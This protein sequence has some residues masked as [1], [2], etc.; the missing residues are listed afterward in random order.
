MK[1]MKFPVLILI[2][3]ALLLSATNAAQCG[4]QARGALCKGGL[5]CSKF[6]YCGSTKAYCGPGCQSQC[7]AADVKNDHVNNVGGN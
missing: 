4:R 2:T 1:M 5:C 6:G 3:L 7:K